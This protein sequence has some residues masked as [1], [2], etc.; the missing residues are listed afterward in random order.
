MDANTDIAKVIWDQLYKE[1]KNPFGVAALMGNLF[2]ESSLNPMCM[3]G[4]NAKG[5]DPDTYVTDVSKGKITSEQFAHDG[6]AFGL[7]Q[8]LYWS[9]KEKL[10]EFSK[11]DGRSIANVNLQIAFLLQEIKTYQT[12]WRTILEAKNV[13]EP[14]DIIME[15]YEKP[16]NVSTQ[17]KTKREFFGM[18]Y[19][20]AFAKLYERTDLA[21]QGK[22]ITTRENVLIRSGNGK[23]YPTVGRIDICGTVL[24]WVATS[25]NDWHAVVATV[26]HQ[27][28]VVWISGE[29]TKRVD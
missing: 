26:S 3:T 12:V 24:P 2:A 15:R 13:K 11:G 29:F 27:K 1:I 22:V 7:A 20:D 17:A 23:E 16:S 5:I 25:Q 10:Y 9:R 18:E 6:I 19:Y 21:T 4:K 28:R 8:W 14:S